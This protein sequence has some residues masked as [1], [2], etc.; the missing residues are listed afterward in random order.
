MTNKDIARALRETADLIE[1]TGGN[2]YRA[3]AFN[4]AARS[5]RGLDE[6]ASDRLA[7]GTLTDVSGIGDA[8]AQHVA[9]LVRTGS[10]DQHDELQNA[11]PPGLL[12]MMRVKGLGTKKVRTLWT[13]LD[14][15][16]LDGLERAAREDQITRLSGFGAKT[17][18]NILENVQRLRAY[19]K[20]RRYADAVAALQPVLQGLREANVVTRAEVTGAMRRHVETVDRADLLVIAPDPETLVATLDDLLEADV[21]RDGDTI[22]S[23]LDDGLPLVVHRA[24]ADAFGTAWWRTTGSDAH[25]EAFEATYGSPPP[26]ATEDALFAEAGLSPIPP[27]LRENDGELDAAA[28]D[29]LPRLID[30]DDLQGSLHNHS[31]YS[32]GAHSLRAMAEAARSLGLS[33]FGICDHSQSLQVAHG[34]SPDAVR[35]QWSE[36][37][38]LNDAFA[39]DDG[40]P[41]RIFRGIESDILG[42]GSLDYADDLLAG[43]DFV[44]ASVH[45]KFGMTEAEATE[46]IVTAVQ[47]PHT[48]ILGHPTGRLLLR[49]EGY[50]LDHEAVLD[51]CAAHD[52][53][54]EINANPYRLDLDWRWIGPALDRGILLSINPDA[55]ATSELQYVKWGVAVARKGGLSVEGCLNAKSLP[56]FAEWIDDGPDA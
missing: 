25:C 18:A 2:P 23:T 22:R 48:R 51:A 5:I 10:F 45:T 30:V 46:R 6:P 41:F 54:I 55:H 27:E 47:N 40:P 50:P 15:T 26:L 33:Y 19:D 11:V 44:V 16:S 7:D 29:A 13:E 39:S 14:L 32:D 1:L 17:Q 4:R 43:F 28:H 34:L 36:I 8:M 37:D 20:Q 52:V 3:N 42:D 24:D 9:D 35:E 21:E 49:R 38:T 56:A 31:T 53:A 12:D